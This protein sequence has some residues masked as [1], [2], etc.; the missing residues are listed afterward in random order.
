M[1]ERSGS[2]TNN[3]QTQ[4]EAGARPDR[5]NPLNERTR[6]ESLPARPRG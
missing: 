5:V 2:Y 1:N 3:L 6:F 4:L